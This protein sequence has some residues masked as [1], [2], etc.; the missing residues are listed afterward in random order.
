MDELKLNELGV[1]ALS[2]LYIN[3]KISPTEVTKALLDRI[4][5]E[6]PS[7][8][9][10]LTVTAEKALVEAEAAEKRIMKGI[11]LSAVDGIPMA[12]KDII[13]T[14]DITTTFG[15]E[16][17]KNFIP[18]ENAAIVEKLGALGMPL[19]GKTNTHQF[20]LGVTTDC[21]YFGA[22]RNPYNLDRGC[23]GS[24]GGS[25]CALAAK[26]TP[27][28]LGTDTGGS[29][30]IPASYCGIVGMK[31][32]FGSVSAAGILPLSYSLD[33]VGPMTRFVEDNAMMLNAMVGYDSK[34]NMSL[35]RKEEDFSRFIGEDIKNLI[36]GVPYG[37][38]E[39]NIQFGVKEKVLKAIEK[40]KD[41]GAVIREITLPDLTDYRTAHQK[42]LTAEAYQIHRQDL[43]QHPE[44][45]D[46]SVRERLLQGAI[47]AAEYIDAQFLKQKFSS[48]FADI[49]ADID[50]I[51]LP[52]TAVTATKVCN[53]MIDINGKESLIYDPATRFTWIA[54]LN[55]YPSLSMP[56]GFSEGLP[57]G[58]QI[59]G[60]PLSEAVIYKTAYQLETKLAWV[61]V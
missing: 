11:P 3:K 2:T 34:Y 5:K 60:K 12:V 32:T 4:E 61:L 42:I 28:A 54:D 36:I 51:V 53:S 43:A 27:F 33:H 30:R 7:L 49:F 47:T 15:C 10:Y 26:L 29:I 16:I 52:S 22:T 8:N 37:Y 6:N 31:P 20:A 21:N 44:M 48:L 39:D 59:M 56:V 23:G 24:S 38:F 9:A 41:M 17:Y 57:V 25:G 46:D 45:I 35:K 14:K 1:K 19:L 58:F 55:G 50:L 40:L 18:K 13:H